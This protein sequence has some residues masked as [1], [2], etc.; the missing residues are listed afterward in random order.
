MFEMFAQASEADPI[1][2]WGNLTATAAMIGLMTWLITKGMPS[3]LDRHDKVMEATRAHFEEVLNKIDSRRET[4]A[5]E[6]HDA[7]K[8]LATA[9][10][11]QC[12]TLSENTFA[13]RELGNTIK[14][15]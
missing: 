7:A 9:I 8:V 5:R 4:A 3:L 14:A 12:D 11:K 10:D 2:T 6:G 13:I 1:A 15:R